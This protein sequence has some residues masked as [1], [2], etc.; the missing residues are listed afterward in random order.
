MRDAR[1][2]TWLE[3]TE[4][5]RILTTRRI[6]ET[7]PLIGQLVDDIE[8]EGGYAAGFIAYGAAPAFDPALPVKAD[9]EFPLLWF[10]WFEQVHEIALPLHDPASSLVLPWRPSLTSA[11][12][13]AS[14]DV[15]HQLIRDGDAYQVNFTY[16]LHAETDVDPWNLFLQI[17]GDAT[18]PFAA[19]I[20]TGEWAI[21]S[22]SPELFLRLDGRHIESRPM[23]GTAARGMWFEDDQAQQAMLIHSKKERAENLMI[24]D[25]VRNDLGRIA[26]CG[27]VQVPSLFAIEK[28]PTVWQMT[29]TVCAETDA[30]LAQILQATFPPASITG[31]PKRRTMEIIAELES[32]SRRVYTGAIG[33]M[34]PERQAQF[35]VAIRTVLLHKASGRAEYG[36]GSGIVWD[37]QPD[38]EYAECLTKTRV[39]N[40]APRDFELLE[41]LRWSPSEGYG[42]LERHLQRLA[43]SADY[44]DFPVDLNAVR[45][46][47]TH[48]ATSLP[49]KPHRVRLR[50]CRRGNLQSEAIPLGAMAQRFGDIVLASEPVDIREVFLYHKTTRRGV[51]EAAVRQCPGSDDVLLFN[52][53]GQI[54][55][56]TIA[57]VAV[58]IDGVR[59]T[60]PVRCGLLPG[61]L[62]AALLDSGQLQERIISIR[63]ALNSPNVYLLNSV[64]GMHRVRVRH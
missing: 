36:C 43:R 1:R 7:L 6:E 51:Y 62:R 33:F 14:L 22:A 19:F 25:M 4:L 57:N 35:N 55:E 24:V 30:S 58:E 37:S 10:G 32:S 21:C 49:L 31:A 23:K 54:T 16:R 61:T 11:Q 50:V 56:S 53:A 38:A 59:Y 5:R 26:H 60:P 46:E 42:L 12:Y 20:D 2:G 64:R 17:A 27:S 44:F 48:M 41:T 8:R 28:Y 15:I 3:F 39:L 34:G 45:Q 40:P 29:S 18:A 47:L 13:H 63:E 52:A 9:K